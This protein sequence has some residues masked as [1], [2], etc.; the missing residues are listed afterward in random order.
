MW[1]PGSILSFKNWF[2]HPTTQFRPSRSQTV[3][4]Y[5]L[6]EPEVSQ[7]QRMWQLLMKVPE[8]K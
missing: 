6:T 7:L 2:F 5:T 8:T 3:G 1:S 4:N